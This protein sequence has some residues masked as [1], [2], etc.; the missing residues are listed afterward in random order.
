MCS[1]NCD[2]SHMTGN[3]RQCS[4]ATGINENVFIRCVLCFISWCNSHAYPT[5]NE[6][7]WTFTICWD[8]PDFPDF[9]DFPDFPDFPVFFNTGAEFSTLKSNWLWFRNE[10]HNWHDTY[11][12]TSELI[13]DV[14]IDESL[15]WLS[16]SLFNSVSVG[17]LKKCNA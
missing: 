14:G 6:D 17:A 7:L 5:E 13:S 11:F 8:F 2:F 15:A 9:L 4:W 16:S 3:N 1:G 12:V 10:F